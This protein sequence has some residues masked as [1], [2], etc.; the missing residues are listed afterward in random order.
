MLMIVAYDREDAE[1]FAKEHKIPEGFWHYAESPEMIAGVFWPIG[2]PYP[3]QS[4]L[5]VPGYEK[6]KDAEKFEQVAEGCWFQG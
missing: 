4:L 1:K 3:S 2:C 6:R 5:F